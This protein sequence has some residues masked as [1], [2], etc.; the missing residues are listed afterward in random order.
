MGQRNARIM[1]LKLSLRHHHL[2]HRHTIL[3]LECFKP[4]SS[5]M[6]LTP[7]S[8]IS[9]SRISS[10]S[11]HPIP[12][13]IPQHTHPRPLRVQTPKHWPASLQRQ[14]AINHQT[15]HPA[16]DLHVPFLQARIHIRQTND[17]VEPFTNLLVL[18][19][20]AVSAGRWAAHLR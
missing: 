8:L 19:L 2:S 12:S 17:R 18:P 6:P 13:S 3:Q 4:T 20:R 7:S 11:L 10:P 9:T 15:H 14:R 5:S 16:Q 1:I